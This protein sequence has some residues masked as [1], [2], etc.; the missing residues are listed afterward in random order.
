[1]VHYNVSE[2]KQYF[3]SLLNFALKLLSALLCVDCIHDPDI[4]RLQNAAASLIDRPIIFAF[5]VFTQSYQ[6]TV[7]C[8][9]KWK[10]DGFGCSYVSLLLQYVKSTHTIFMTIVQCSLWS[11]SHEGFISFNVYIELDLLTAVNKARDKKET[12]LF[13]QEHCF[14]P[15]EKT[16]KMN[17]S[18]KTIILC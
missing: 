2:S 1:M 11:W 6:V 5:I 17:F 3:T 9:N 10:L 4:S 12:L 13:V 8:Y 18:F 15:N 16:M 14:I 7:I